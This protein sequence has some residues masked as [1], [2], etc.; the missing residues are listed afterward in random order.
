MSKRTF[1]SKS[2]KFKIQNPEHLNNFEIHVKNTT[3]NSSNIVME[4]SDTNGSSSTKNSHASSE[5]SSSLNKNNGPQSGKGLRR[6]KN[7][8][9]LYEKLSS[10]EKGILRL[11]A[12]ILDNSLNPPSMEDLPLVLNILG[13]SQSSSTPLNRLSFYN[14]QLETKSDEVRSLKN[15]NRLLQDSNESLTLELSQTKEKL[16]NLK[17]NSS[18]TESSELATAKVKIVTLEKELA[19]NKIVR[20][21][22]PRMNSEEI[23]KL[24]HKLTQSEANCKKASAKADTAQKEIKRLNDK[25]KVRDDIAKQNAKTNALLKTSSGDS[26]AMIAKLQD[27]LVSA[28]EDKT[29]L[30]EKQEQKEKEFNKYKRI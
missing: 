1:D 6:A 11:N 30:I 21:S 26:T 29:R 9:N 20:K 7:R 15:F 3:A 12:F 18:S 13:D 10:F 27:Q 19:E 28:S 17:K 24:Q 25:I 4:Y 5:A 23:L 14:S 16:E 8:R 2:K 22:S